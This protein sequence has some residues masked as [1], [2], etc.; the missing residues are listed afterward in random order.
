MEI[1]AGET[2]TGLRNVLRARVDGGDHQSQILQ[3]AGK[4][5][6]A[7]PKIEGGPEAQIGLPGRNRAPQKVY[8]RLTRLRLQRQ[9]ENERL[10]QT[11][12][13]CDSYFAGVERFPRET[14]PRAQEE[15]SS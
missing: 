10:G 15:Q 13:F 5:S 12:S 2:A 4:I 14:P 7:A 11:G 3:Q 8:L 9:I 1:N 6:H